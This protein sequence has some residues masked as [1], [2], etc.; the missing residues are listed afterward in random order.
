MDKSLNLTLL[1]YDYI[2]I[3]RLKLIDV[4]KIV[5]DI[6]DNFEQHYMK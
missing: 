3:M 2:T 6:R 4:D 1:A 5:R